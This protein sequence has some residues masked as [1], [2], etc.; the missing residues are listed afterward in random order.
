MDFYLRCSTTI[1]RKK[2]LA[3]PSVDL[4]EISFDLRQINGLLFALLHDDIQ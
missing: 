1:Y 2:L 4:R 3:M